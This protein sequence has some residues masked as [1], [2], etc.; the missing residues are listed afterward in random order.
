M[1]Y[2]VSMLPERDPSLGSSN[3]VFSQH[4][5]SASVL[6]VPQ[7]IECIACRCTSSWEFVHLYLHLYIVQTLVSRV[8]SSAFN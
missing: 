3:H 2:N 4:R 5:D 6:M 1:S 8:T 7:K